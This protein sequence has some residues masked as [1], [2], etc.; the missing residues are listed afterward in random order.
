MREGGKGLI[1]DGKWGRRA[2]VGSLVGS[3][4]RWDGQMVKTSLGDVA[5]FLTF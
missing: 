3:R 5:S 2:E 4:M 1:S